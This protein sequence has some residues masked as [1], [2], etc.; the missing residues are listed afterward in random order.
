MWKLEFCDEV[1]DVFED[2]LEYFGS[3]HGNSYWENEN[4][5]LEACSW[6]IDFNAMETQFE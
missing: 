2:T 3:V 1:H 6:L 5:Q 4:R